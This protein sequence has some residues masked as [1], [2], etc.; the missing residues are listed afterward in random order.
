METQDKDDLALQIRTAHRL[1][2]AYYQRLL[3]TIEQVASDL[4]YQFYVW[5]P[6]DFSKPS[7]LGTHPANKWAW[8]FLPGAATHYVYYDAESNNKI[9]TAESLFAL[10]V[11]SDSALLSTEVS[12]FGKNE[13]DALNLSLPVDEARSF[14]R[15]FVFVANGDYERNWNNSVWHGKQHPKHQRA[16][17]AEQFTSVELGEWGDFCVPLTDLMDEEKV[18]D[19]LKRIEALKITVREKATGVS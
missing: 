12:G 17:E 3:P 16:E 18:S 9:Q 14:V 1:L 8:D 7:Q 10:T 11:V 5:S 19:L 15:V 4:G 2:G 6:A 13:P